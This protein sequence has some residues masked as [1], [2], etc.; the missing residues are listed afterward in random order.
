M[1]QPEPDR[2]TFRSYLIFW[3]GQLASLAGTNIV[4]FSLTWWIT[5]QTGSAFFLG[6]SAFF[7]FGSF[8][9][10]TPIAGVLVDRWSRKKVII[11]AD[12]LLALLSF[13][14][15][16]L[17][18]IGIANIIHVLILQLIGGMVGAFHAMAVQAIIPIMVARKH[19]TRMNSLN[20]FATAFIQTIGPAIG[21]LVFLVFLGDMARILFID[22]G[23]YLIAIIP[24]ILVT[25]PSV[26]MMKI[27]TEKPSFRREFS[28]GLS[29]IRTRS[30]L[31]TLLTLFAI[32]NFLLPPIFI[33]LP[34]FSTNILALGD[35]NLAVIYLATLL[36]LQ[37]GSMMVASAVMMVWGG[38]K[39]N[40]IGVFL[41]IFCGAFGMIIIAL[42]PPGIFWVAAF[43]VVL[44]GFTLPIAN[45][46]SQ[47]IWQKMVPPEKL[48]R[49]FSVRTT[50]AQ[51]TAPF[52]FLV[53]GIFAELFSIPLIFIVFGSILVTVL[54][55]AWVLTDLPRVEKHLEKDDLEYMKKQSS[56]EKNQVIESE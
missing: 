56:S 45:V 54:I 28:E 2:K 41:G 44:I 33:L 26:R 3:G 27:V 24:A 51:F 48:G 19:L 1:E 42:T 9:L 43:G 8:I 21:A 17:F 18:F 20:L 30:G 31:L 16:I 53:A 49:V 47:T 15:V 32:T 22:I 13:V 14:L 23:T 7:G 10:I 52:A 5:I 6:I 46:S 25:I 38:F 40:I 37:S 4:N 39:R 55:L 36:S 29:F 12:S 50:I 34:L 11:I 35:L